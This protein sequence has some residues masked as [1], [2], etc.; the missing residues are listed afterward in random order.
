MHY[1]KSGPTH[2][3]ALL[4]AVRR[5]NHHRT[6]VHL[7][8]GQLADV[9]RTHRTATLAI[10]VVVARDPTVKVQPL[11]VQRCVHTGWRRVI[12]VQRQ[13]GGQMRW[14]QQLPFVPFSLVHTRPVG[15][16][17]GLVAE[18]CRFVVAAAVFC[19]SP[20]GQRKHQH[21]NGGG[22]KLRFHG[23]RLRCGWFVGDWV[24]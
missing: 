10:G 2:L 4:A 6:I 19:D 8:G 23:D 3:E 22:Q 15:H 14:H 17:V 1:A 21:Q 5:L 11:A 18:D 13:I 20:A 24:G 12:R 7:I 16:I 9:Q